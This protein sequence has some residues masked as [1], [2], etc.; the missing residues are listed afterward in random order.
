MDGKTR[1]SH[2]SIPV[3]HVHKYVY[4]RELLRAVNT[5]SGVDDF[6]I[7]VESGLDVRLG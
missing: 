4:S 2:F 1:C 6:G 7:Q 5:H 3:N